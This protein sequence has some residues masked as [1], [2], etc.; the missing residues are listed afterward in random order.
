MPLPEMLLCSFLKIKKIDQLDF[1]MLWKFY[2]SQILK[3]L[4]T[5][6]KDSVCNL[7]LVKLS[8]KTHTSSP[9]QGHVSTLETCDQLLHHYG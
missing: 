3:V 4:R 8:T 2:T 9:W 1:A 7:L 5:L 6:S